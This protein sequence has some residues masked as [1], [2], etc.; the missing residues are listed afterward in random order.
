LE[1]V[2]QKVLSNKLA[3]KKALSKKISDADGEVEK[4]EKKEV[5]Y[6]FSP[7]AIFLDDD[8]RFFS[9]K[10]L[11]PSEKFHAQVIYIIL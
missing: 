10:V 6:R 1:K 9:H 5:Y 4:T 8:G 3:P 2:L 11:K 7:S